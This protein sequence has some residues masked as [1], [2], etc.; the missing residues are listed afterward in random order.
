MEGL[1]PMFFSKHVATERGAVGE[2]QGLK[3][4]LLLDALRG[5]EAPLFHGAAGGRGGGGPDG[6]AGGRGECGR[7]HGSLEAG[8]LPSEK[9]ASFRDARSGLIRIAIVFAILVL[10]SAMAAAQTGKY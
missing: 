9:R 4:R 1:I 2:A 10:V 8:T 3:P 6:A 5:A 7:G